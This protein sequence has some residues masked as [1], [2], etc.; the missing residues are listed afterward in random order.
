MS[1]MGWFDNLKSV[2]NIDSANIQDA[3]IKILSGNTV[4]VQNVHISIDAAHI[5]QDKI[6][7]LK[8]ILRAAVAE[9]SSQDGYLVASPPTEEKL[10][11]I[12]EFNKS[13]PDP[14]ITKF[15][16][17]N[18]PQKDQSIWLAA[19]I[20]RKHFQE[21]KSVAQLKEDIRMR[22]PVKGANISNLCS[23]GYLETHIIPLHEYLVGKL[24]DERRFIQVYDTIVNE[25]PY[26][27]FAS[28]FKTQQ[29][30]KAE[31]VKKIRD[32]RQNGWKRVS[33]HGIGAENV[34]KIKKTM[35]EVESE[36][37]E[38]ESTEIEADQQ[39]IKVTFI[40]D[41]PIGELPDS[42]E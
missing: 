6:L 38:V 35:I 36:C 34:Q 28:H 10:E 13:D 25:M 23:A 31:L 20:I 7:E 14:Q 12:T 24:N 4:K 3:G 26:A 42:T 2:F 19:L 41:G 16:V 1:N 22:F 30:L 9:S 17:S 32:V 29:E 8:E 33:V 37:S 15:V 39:V 5:N 11:L 40:L 27:V 21:K 18:I